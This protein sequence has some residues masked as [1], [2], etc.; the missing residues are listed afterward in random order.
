VGVQ[1]KICGLSTP[2]SIT[3]AV[4]GG[5]SFLGFVFFPPSP[6]Y[7]P[8][9]EALPLVMPVPKDVKRVGLVVNAGDDLL[10]AITE[11]LPLEYLQLHGD[12]SPERVATIRMRTNLPVIKVLKI[13][14]PED[15][16]QV[17]VYSDI[18]DMLLFDAKPPEGADRPG[19]HGAPFDWDI[20]KG[21]ETPLP[22]L[23]GGGLTSENVTEA[24]DRTGAHM[25]DVSSGVEAAKGVKDIGRIQA[26]LKAVKAV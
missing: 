3:A 7:I 15:L 19:G 6:R 4:A 18:S 1:V 16:G 9:A 23:L 21:L 20:L 11:T 22:W 12:E 8:V 14:T 13:S 5:A 2:E 25:V 26:F 10:D 17:K 24:I